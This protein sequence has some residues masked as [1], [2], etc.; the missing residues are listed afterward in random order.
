MDGKLYIVS[1]KK[2]REA[3]EYL[4]KCVDGS[5][6]PFA[7]ERTEL[8]SVREYLKGAN[9]LTPAD[10]LV[11]VGAADAWAEETAGGEVRFER[12]GLRCVLRARRAL[13]TAE[14]RGVEGRKARRDFLAWLRTA[15]P[16]LGEGD[17]AAVED[18][19]R[20]ALFDALKATV[21]P[22][23][24]VME[25]QLVAPPGSGDLTETERLQYKALANIF[26]RELLPGWA[27]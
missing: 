20:I 13:L 15:C 17:L 7:G 4:E 24:M 18:E 1:G 3:A 2:T 19:R 14:A 10:A 23:G 8:W 6:S 26:V 11:F 12:F 9:A 25:Q 5:S 21:N 22:L 16:A 27:N